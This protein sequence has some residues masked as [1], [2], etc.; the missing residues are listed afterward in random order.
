MEIIRVDQLSF[1]YPDTQAAALDNV[2]LSVKKGDFVVLCGASGCGKTTLLR[3]LKQEAQPTG[4]RSGSVLFNG[5]P[6]GELP[7][8]AAAEQIGMVFQNPE[9]QIVMDQVWH[10]LAFSMENIGY[11]QAVMR[12]RLAE[13]SHFFGLEDLLYKSVHEISGGQ[14]QLIN[15]ASVLLLQPKLLL[16]DEPTSQLDPVAARDFLQLIYRLNQE[17]SMT[18]IISE[19]RLEDVIPL[20]DRIIM[21]DGGRVK[22]D[23]EPRELCRLISSDDASTDLPYLPSV[24]K[25]YLSAESA[26]LSPNAIEIPLTVREG[27]QWLAGIGGIQSDPAMQADELTN[28]RNEKKELLLAC[29]EMTFK[30]EKD[31]PEV[32]KKLSLNVY[33]HEFLAVLGGNGTGKTTMLQMMAGLLK[34]QRG[35]LKREKGVK[36]GYLAQNPLLY[37]SFDT[38]EEELQRMAD[39]AGLAEREHKIASVAAALQIADLMPKHPY[40][41][42][43]GEQQRAALALVLLGEPDILCLDEPTKGLDPIA[44]QRTAE[45][46]Q[47]LCRSGKTIVMVTHDIEFAAEHA[48]RCAMLFDGAISAEAAPAPFFGTNYFYTTAINRTVREWLPEALTTGD[49][50]DQWVK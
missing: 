18:V 31:G 1:Y 48:S 42:S 46:L 29:E 16:L 6:L 21:L 12:K 14:K 38:V 37:F 15:L 25:L 10:E 24:S 44:K 17:M 2:S 23:A 36:V 41:L 8:V 26:R 50:M 7:A 47:Q 11:A 43:G 45:L 4:K 34:P 32:L 20:A 27:K 28:K 19:H 3:H 49:V 33:K 9:N 30:Y 39:Y 5:I 40:D 35:R 22:Y 13:M